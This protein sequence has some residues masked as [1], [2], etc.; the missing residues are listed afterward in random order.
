MEDIQ[1]VETISILINL[2]PFFNMNSKAQILNFLYRDVL[3][4]YFGGLACDFLQNID[5]EM[6]NIFLHASSYF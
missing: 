3:S 4:L 1:K 2:V 6:L 5:L